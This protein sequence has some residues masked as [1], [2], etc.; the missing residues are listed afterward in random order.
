MFFACSRNAA[1]VLV[2]SWNDNTG[3]EILIWGGK[4]LDG[5]WENRKADE[6]YTYNVNWEFS[7]YD[8][9]LAEAACSGCYSTWMLCQPWAAIWK[10]FAVDVYKIIS[11]SHDPLY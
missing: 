9:T 1:V 4:C 3:E 10:I 7:Y 6:L 11:I 2:F 8:I 5:Y